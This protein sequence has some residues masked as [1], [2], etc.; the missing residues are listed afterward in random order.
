MGVFESLVGCLGNCESL[1]SVGSG[2]DRCYVT[3]LDMAERSLELGIK[4]RSIAAGEAELLRRLISDCRQSIGKVE[5]LRDHCVRRFEEL[6]KAPSPTP[7]SPAPQQPTPQPPPQPLTPPPLSSSPTPPPTPQQ[8]PQPLTLNREF[9]RSGGTWG[10]I[11]SILGLVSSLLFSLTIRS[12]QLFPQAPYLGIAAL[13]LVA[14]FG[15]LD[16][17]ALVLFALRR[18][19]KAYGN[20][21]IW[22]NALYS[23]I[24]AVAGGAALAA[25]IAYLGYLLSVTPVGVNEV[26]GV[27][28]VIS[29]FALFYIIILIIAYF[30]RETYN[31]LSKSS[32][33]GDFN[34]AAKWYWLGALLIIVL[35]IGSLLMIV[36]A[37]YAILGYNKLRKVV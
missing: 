30:M 35:G 5:T 20:R 21:A 13:A 12:M 18:L 37:I 1:Y 23:L 16:G 8:L 24:T 7:T 27:I 9:I 25:I 32:G 28:I 2:R 34:L 3:C 6:R 19:S 14:L 17:Y 10:F 29:L 33:I 36:A 15:S 31:E 4:D 22:T 11:G 26:A